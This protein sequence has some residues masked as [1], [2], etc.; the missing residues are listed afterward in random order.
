MHIPKNGG[1]TINSILNRIYSKNNTFSVK[2]INNKRSNISEFVDLPKKEKTKIKLLK[3]HMLFGLHT[4]L[5]GET[6]YFTFLRK[7][8]D[9]LL[10]YYH[11]VKNRPEHRVY[12]Q[13]QLPLP[14]LGQG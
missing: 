4:H 7:P 1:S 2:E 12:R 8:E 10:S 3:G 9:R 5:E 6:S 11:Y 13:A 14:P